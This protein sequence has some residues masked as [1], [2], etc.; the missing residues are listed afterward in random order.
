MEALVER[1]LEHRGMSVGPDTLYEDE[2]LDEPLLHALTQL[3][4]HGVD[5]GRPRLIWFGFVG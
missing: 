2:G 5:E 1:V 3:L 4:C